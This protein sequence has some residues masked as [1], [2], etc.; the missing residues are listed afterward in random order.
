MPT[1]AVAARPGIGVA[2]EKRLHAAGEIGLGR[3]EN[4][5]QVIG[6]DS[7]RI[8]MPGTPNGGSPEVFSEPIAVNVIAYDVLTRVA[9]SHEVVDSVRI[10]EA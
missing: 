7:E 3:L 9:A 1:K 2:G 10:L 6:H 8:N 4:D 5:V